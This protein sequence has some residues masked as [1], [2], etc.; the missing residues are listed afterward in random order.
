MCVVFEVVG[1][2]GSYD[3]G[4]ANCMVGYYRVRACSKS[5]HSLDHNRDHNP[6]GVEGGPE[7]STETPK[8]KRPRKTGLLGGCR[9]WIR[10]R[11]K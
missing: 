10:T 5:D 3:A 6:T 7:G 4:R 2:P 1:G 8:S 9:T 11:T